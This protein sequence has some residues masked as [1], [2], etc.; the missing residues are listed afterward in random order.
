MKVNNQ[1]NYI[2]QFKQANESDSIEFQFHTNMISALMLPVCHYRHHISRGKYMGYEIKEILDIH[3]T[4]I[5]T[6]NI[7]LPFFLSDQNTYY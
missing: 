4:N 2:A 7:L 6:T 3:F 5:I 1:I